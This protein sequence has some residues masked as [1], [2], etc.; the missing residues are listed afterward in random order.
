MTTLLVLAAAIA[1]GGCATAGKSRAVADANRAELPEDQKPRG[2][3]HELINSGYIENTKSPN[4][5]L[6]P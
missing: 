5:S 4:A 6:Y 3:I 1:G 2:F